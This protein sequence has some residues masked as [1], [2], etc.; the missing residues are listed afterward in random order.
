MLRASSKGRKQKNN[1]SD[2]NFIIIIQHY[3]SGVSKNSGAINFGPVVTTGLFESFIVS[4][5]TLEIIFFLSSIQSLNSFCSSFLSCRAFSVDFLILCMSSAN[6]FS[7][8]VINSAGELFMT[9]IGSMSSN[10]VWS[11][12]STRNFL[13]V[14]GNELK[15]LTDLGSSERCLCELLLIGRDCTRLKNSS[16]FLSLEFWSKVVGSH[17]GLKYFMNKTVT[18]FTILMYKFSMICTFWA[19]NFFK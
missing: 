14:C 8:S 13:M 11:A 15:S 10:M 17:I 9:F 2:N 19:F 5:F 6:P 4:I 3:I 12:S 16:I 1:K 7:L 18:F